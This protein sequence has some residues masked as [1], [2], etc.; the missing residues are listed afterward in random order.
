MLEDWIMVDR[1][2]TDKGRMVAHFILLCICSLIF[3][4]I[5]VAAISSSGH[6]TVAD[7]RVP[8]DEESFLVYEQEWDDEVAAALNS[9][10]VSIDNIYQDQGMLMLN[11]S[12]R[13][14]PTDEESYQV[15]NLNA[16]DYQNVNC[17]RYNKTQ[18]LFEYSQQMENL[19]M[20][21]YGGYYVIPND[22]VNPNIV[23]TFIDTYTPYTATV[24]GNVVTIDMANSEAI[25]TYNEEGILT[26]EE[27]KVN[28][29]L[30]KTLSMVVDENDPLATILIVTFTSTGVICAVLVIY[31]KKRQN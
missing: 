13:T 26:R 12:V 7:S 29:E 27:L 8:V 24:Q 22:P 21:C 1:K 28:G 17:L 31:Y 23:K 19:L 18:Q 6:F 3:C 16:I 20:A 9:T 11:I 25:L 10:E 4:I 30:V 5:P 14:K 15:L 2:K